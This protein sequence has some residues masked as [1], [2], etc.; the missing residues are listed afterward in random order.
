MATPLRVLILEDNPSDAAQM[1]HSLR[2]DG[3]DLMVKVVETEQE[4]RDSLPS[5]PEAILADFTLPAFSALGALQILRENE[6]DIPCII[7]SGS[8]DQERAVQILQRGAAD[9]VMKDSL[10]RLGQSV[11]VA[12]EKKLL[13]DG[14]READRLL[15]HSACLLTL[16]AEVAIAL[17]KGD[18]LE[19]MLGRCAESLIRNLD[20]AFARIWTF[21]T[22]ETE[23]ELRASAASAIEASGVPAT[24]PP[25]SRQVDQFVQI[26]QSYSTNAAIGDPRVVDQT[27]AQR[28]HI[29][30]FSGHPLIVEGRIVGVLAIYSRQAIPPPTLDALAALAVN[31]AMGIERKD[32]EQSLAAAKEA[33]EAANRS[34]SQFLANVSHEIRT[35]MNGILGLT[36]L[37]LGTSLT[38]EQ[39]QYVDGVKL[40]AE[41]LMQV[42][43]D[44]LDFSKIEAGRVDLESI[45]LDLREMLGDTLKVLAIGAQK[46]GLELIFEIRPDV[47]DSLMGDPTRL[48]QVVVNLVGNALKFTSQG[49]ISVVV[50]ATPSTRESVELH[51][52]V[53]DSG[54]GIPAAKQ[55]AI[56]EAF[57][58]V[59]GSTTRIYGGTGLGLTISAQ[60]VKMMGG[61]M[62]V[63]SEVGRGSKFHF[64][65]QLTTSI[66]TAVHESPLL[67]AELKNLRILVVDDSTTN[68]RILKDILTRWHLRPVYADG[69]ANALAAIQNAVDAGQ[70]F[71]L[72]MLDLRMPGIDGFSVMQHMRRKASTTVP[73]ILMVNSSCRSED[74]ARGC[75]FGAAACLIKPIKPSE[76]LNAIVAALSVPVVQKDPQVTIAAAPLARPK[77]GLNILV[78]EDNAINRMVISRILE[79]AGHNVVVAVNGQEAV[80][81]LAE[82][83]FDLVL[84]DVQMPVMD[85]FEA[86]AMIRANEFNSDR[87]MPVVAMTAHAMNGDRERCLEAG[88]DGYVPKPIQEDLLFQ[89]LRG[90]HYPIATTGGRWRR[91]RPRNELPAARSVRSGRERAD[92]ARERTG[93]SRTD[94]LA[95]T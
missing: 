89:T 40:S 7:V 6:L 36:T 16:S 22:S 15:R 55:Q 75:Q 94:R 88:M 80:I 84:M 68:G 17:T 70:P 2:H 19:E 49:E 63:E 93:T 27:W 4:F 1:V 71:G 9:Y 50:Q 23:L 18:T 66:A 42:I 90:R 5:N 37:V 79:R 47:P 52:T 69:G 26:G 95:L 60:L 73:T 72:V 11:R 35:P 83:N 56:F 87:H 10:G 13:R 91:D 48:R 92:C 65:A 24:G 67:P 61:Q 76:M 34:K 45:H 78:A 28:E 30:A 25:D 43:N 77:P 8:I 3:F 32:S 81:A 41:A 46:K 38:G 86:T 54:I 59:D 31:I 64:T 21:N 58:Q 57:T 29:V 51:F 14:M 44:I 20:A 12:L 85:G 82:A 53:S 33:A 39:R 74:L 62:W